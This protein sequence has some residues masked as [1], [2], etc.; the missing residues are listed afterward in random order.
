MAKKIKIRVRYQHETTV[1]IYPNEI[2]D[3]V[4][5]GKTV[6]AALGEY[7]SETLAEQEW[8]SFVMNR[9]DREDALKAIAEALKDEDE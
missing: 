6:E 3:D 5:D 8:P 9:D 1:E 2:A 7:V 4:R